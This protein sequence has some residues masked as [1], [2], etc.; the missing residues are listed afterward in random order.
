MKPNTITL[1]EFKERN[2]ANNR[3]MALQGIVNPYNF[4]HSH[5]V[6]QRGNMV[7]GYQRVKTEVNHGGVM[8]AIFKVISHLFGFNKKRK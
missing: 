6:A 1:Q 2:L 7:R 3:M 5:G 8:R 4:N